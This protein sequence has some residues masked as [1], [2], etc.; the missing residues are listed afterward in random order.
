MSKDKFQAKVILTI[1]ISNCGKST[2]VKDFVKNNP[3]YSD[4]N[5]DDIRVALFCNSNIN[6]YVNY[7]FTDDKECLVSSVQKSYAD[8][9]VSKGQGVVI[10]DTNLNPKVRATWKEYAKEKGLP[11][12]EQVFDVPLHVCSSRNRKRNYTVPDRVL[13]SQ[14]LSYRAFKGIPTYIGTAGKPRAI[15]IDVDGTLADMTG[16][17]KPFEWSLV[18][19]DK[20]RAEICELARMYRDAGYTIIIMSGRDG[21]CYED[22]AKWLIEN[23]V[24]FMHLYLREPGDQRPDAVF[25]EECFWANVADNYD[26]KL[27]LDDRTQMVDQWRAMGLQCLQVQPGDF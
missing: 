26:V 6:E 27:V 4:I 20:P 25:K 13:R 1:G 7:K 14:Y 19:G 12:E 16:V 9:A 18:S 22:T 5:R 8:Y 24:P 10:S 11:Y 2:W 17:R 21:V 23:D 3:M 15:I